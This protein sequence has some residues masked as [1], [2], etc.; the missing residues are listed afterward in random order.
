[1]RF[2]RSNPSLFCIGLAALAI[3]FAF[4]FGHHHGS[5][6]DRHKQH[7]DQSQKSLPSILDA[8]RHVHEHGDGHANDNSEAHGLDQGA[9]PASDHEA[10]GHEC[11]TCRT[12]SLPTT[13]VQSS[14]AALFTIKLLGKLSAPLY[15]ELIVSSWKSSSYLPRGPPALAFS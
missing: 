2:F 10:P 11:P 5:E 1:M 12:L 3:Q 9:P 6:H 13:F 8:H 15:C 4:A 7:V 14:L